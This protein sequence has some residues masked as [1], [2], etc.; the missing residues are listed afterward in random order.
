MSAVQFLLN[1][2]VIALNGA[3]IF[4]FGWLVDRRRAAFGAVGEGILRATMLASI[5]ATML[6]FLALLI[7]G[8]E[9]NLYGT[10]LMGGSGSFIAM[11]AAILLYRRRQQRSAVPPV[12]RLRD[13]FS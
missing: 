5:F 11:V 12:K 7:F 10:V 8:G 13:T 9:I 4:G 3:T 1:I 6:W 2:A